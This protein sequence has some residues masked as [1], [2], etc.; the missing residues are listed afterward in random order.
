MVVEFFFIH[1]ARPGSA[2]DGKRGGRR[3]Y[4]YDGVKC[5]SDCI[6]G[7]TM[8]YRTFPKIA[9]H[10][11]STAEKAAGQNRAAT[12]VALFVRDNT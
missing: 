11:Q 3:G 12:L 10:E 7:E 2:V 8:K 4:K 1:E 5:R 6:R 9:S